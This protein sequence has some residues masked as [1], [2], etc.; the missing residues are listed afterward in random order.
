M[1]SV[2]M[3]TY[4]EPLPWIQA[5]VDSIL[6]QTFRDIELVVVVDNPE[7]TQLIELLEAYRAE[8]SNIKVVLNEQNIGLVKSLNKGLA[9][10]TG[11][12]I[13]RMDADD[14][15]DPRRLERQLQEM[16]R[17][18]Y[19]LMGCQVE[20]FWE[21]DSCGI[22]EIPFSHEAC[23]KVLRYM[24][25]V[26]H[27]SWLVKRSVFEQL[28]GYRDMDACEDYDFLL[29]AALKGFQI[30]NM[31]EVLLRYRLNPDSIS[32]LKRGKQRALADML[33]QAYRKGQV[34]TEAEVEA[35][36]ADGSF[37]KRVKEAEWI[38]SL[39]DKYKDNSRKDRYICLVRLLFNGTYF[40]SKF[41]NKYVQAIRQA[42][43]KKRG[44]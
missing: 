44:K 18:D 9:Y 3:S 4:K 35:S 30:G 17:Y 28:N 24:C 21:E 33:A 42:D 38:Y 37:E 32:H 36:Y 15:S 8:K 19:D 10:C 14:I 5:A 13:A 2:L 29:R 34:L 12:Y 16:K 31:P 26:S 40:Q 39:E 25:C 23:C 6:N 43:H 20:K 1:I 22:E 7:N 11:E 41:S 27:P